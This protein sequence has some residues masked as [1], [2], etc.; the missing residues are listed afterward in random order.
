MIGSDSYFLKDCHEQRQK[1]YLERPVNKQPKMTD[2][3]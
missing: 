2:E 3:R 1:A